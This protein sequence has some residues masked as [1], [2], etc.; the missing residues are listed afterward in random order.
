MPF[1]GKT[2]LQKFTPKTVKLN[3]LYKDTL[4]GQKDFTN[5]Q[6]TAIT[7]TLKKHGHSNDEVVSILKGKDIS[8]K[9]ARAISSKLAKSGIKSLETDSRRMVNRYLRTEATKKKNIAGRRR[10]LMMESVQ[11]DIY[12]SKSKNSISSLS[13]PGM[14]KGSSPTSKPRLK[15]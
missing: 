2:Q 1:F 6:K 3:K 4:K 9:T 14:K 15:F 5:D 13:K 10:E 7:K 8:V 12:K 11:E